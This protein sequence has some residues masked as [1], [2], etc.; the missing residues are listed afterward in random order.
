[1]SVNETSSSITDDSR[2]ILQIVLSLTDGYRSIIYIH[3]QS[4]DIKFEG[5]SELAQYFGKI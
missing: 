1:M 5:H 2:V 4:L 3:K